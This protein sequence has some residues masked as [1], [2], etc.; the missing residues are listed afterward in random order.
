MAIGSAALIWAAPARRAGA[1]LL[2]ALSALSAPICSRVLAPVRGECQ[3]DGVLVRRD[4]DWRQTRCVEG[5]KCL[6]ANR[7]LRFEPVELLVFGN[8]IVIV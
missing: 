8:A 5:L 2:A 6:N 3:R 4:A 7:F 1:A